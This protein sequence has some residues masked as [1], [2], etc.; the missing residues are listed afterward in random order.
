M[1]L[2]VV[3]M[4][5]TR[6]YKWIMS[7]IGNYLVILSLLAHHL[8]WLENIFPIL[9]DCYLGCFLNPQATING[10]VQ[11]KKEVDAKGIL[12][13]G[14]ALGMFYCNIPHTIIR[15]RMGQGK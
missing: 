1:P 3:V 12:D 2:M 6:C 13:S 8:M 10:M 9:H 11:D 14:G 15:K 7:M 4:E 5:M